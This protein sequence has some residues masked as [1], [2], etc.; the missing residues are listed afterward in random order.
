MAAALLVS[1]VDTSF[2][3]GDNSP[4]IVLPGEDSVEVGVELDSYSGNLE[5][6]ESVKIDRS[7]IKKLVEAMRRPDQYHISAGSTV[8]HSAGQSTTG[9]EGYISGELSKVVAFDQNGQSQKHC[10]LT[11]EKAYIWGEGSGTWH[12]CSRGNFEVDDELVIPTYEKILELDEE[13]I[14]NADFSL[15][16][17]I[18]CVF[19]ETVDPVSSYRNLYYISVNDGLLVGA[20]SFEGD[21]LVYSLSVSVLDMPQD[22]N[23][24]FSLPDGTVVKTQ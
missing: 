5:M 14:V 23:G 19:V 13:N 4:G 1:M 15:Y 8:Y 12:E 11:A 3:E 22:T 20:Q 16:N 21:M 2:F 7:N 24:I 17:E 6:L 9:T 10:I 18:Y